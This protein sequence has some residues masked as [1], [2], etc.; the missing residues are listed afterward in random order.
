VDLSLSLAIFPNEEATKLTGSGGRD[1]LRKRK[2]RQKELKLFLK[3][4]LLLGITGTSRKPSN[5]R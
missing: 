3:R 2:G 1:I 5:L 4:R